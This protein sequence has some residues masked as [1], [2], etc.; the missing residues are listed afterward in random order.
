MLGAKAVMKRASRKAGVD[1][2][3]HA[4]HMQQTAEVRQG[5]DSN[6]VTGCATGWR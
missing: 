6:S 3:E 5:K 2:D 1:W 4:R